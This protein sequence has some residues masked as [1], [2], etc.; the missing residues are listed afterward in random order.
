MGY[1]IFFNIHEQQC[2]LTLKLR[3]MKISQANY[4]KERKEAIKS[5]LR[6]ANSVSERKYND[7][8]IK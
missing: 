2:K 8:K 7:R 6:T 1:K 3:S 5:T 4:D